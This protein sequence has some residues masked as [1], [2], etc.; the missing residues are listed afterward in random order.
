MS[1]R[2]VIA[3]VIFSVLVALA[4]CASP[5]ALQP[6]AEERGEAGESR[7]LALAI[8]RWGETRFSG[9]LALRRGAGWLHYALLDASGVKLLEARVDA[10]GTSRLLHVKG[11][12]EESGLHGFLGEALIRIFLVEPEALPCSGS[13]W[14]RICRQGAEAKTSHLGPLPWWRVE[15]LAPVDGLPATSYQQPW[16]GVRLVLRP[17]AGD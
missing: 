15:A 17:L 2:Q 1:C 3:L 10:V 14:K 16:I 12:L 11:A 4:G 5:P 6:I 9:L 13:W 7:L 8:E